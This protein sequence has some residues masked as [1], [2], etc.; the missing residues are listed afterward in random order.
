MQPL[1]SEEIA[2][3]KANGYVIK[4]NVLNPTLCSEA[5]NL[6]WDAL[7]SSVSLVRDDPATHVGPFRESDSNSD[8]KHLRV[9]FQ[10]RLRAVENHPTLV[11]LAFAQPLKG[12]V[13]QLLGPGMLHVPSEDH[14]AAEDLDEQSNSSALHTGIR[15]IY[16][17]LPYGDATRRP[18]GF[19]TD[20]HPFFLGMVGL[21][22][23]VPPNGG[24]FT[25]W[26]RS[27]R[28]LY[29]T[30][31]MQYDQPRIPEYDHLPSARGIFHT[32]AFRTEVERL[33]RDTEP[34]ECHGETGDIV[35]WH[36]RC[37]HAGGHNYSSEIRQAILVD[38]SR[39]DLDSL[40]S[41]PPQ[42]DMWRDWSDEV[43]NS[44]LDYS[45]EFA[46]TQHSTQLAS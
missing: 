16:C 1:T 41:D 12:M 3:F 46:E 4:R 39:T 2:Y 32:S 23:D 9:G 35:F 30:F 25:V 36:H 42:Q 11:R 33:L 40:R 29:P 44:G 27:H 38:Y 13:E 8:S 26:P 20:G 45:A 37:G 6:L 34:V 31:V 10:W 14:L 19:H 21:L 15:G 24:A 7:P 18:P 43:R 28:R 5:Q 22:S 17:T